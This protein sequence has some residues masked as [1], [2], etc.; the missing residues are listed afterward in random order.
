MWNNLD[1]FA[2][3]YH[4]DESYIYS[5]AHAIVMTNAKVKWKHREHEKNATD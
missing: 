5:L 3:Y 2:Q 4:H 1:A